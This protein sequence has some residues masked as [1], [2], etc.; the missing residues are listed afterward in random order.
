[1]IP[2]E[3]VELAVVGEPASKMLRLSGL[4]AGIVGP[5]APLYVVVR[6]TLSESEWAAIEAGRYLAAFKLYNRD[7]VVGLVL[8]LVIAGGRLRWFLNYSLRHIAEQGTPE[9]LADAVEALAAFKRDARPGMGL[10]VS[11]VF[12]DV[13][14]L[15][16]VRGLR[17][18]ALPRMFGDRFLAAIDRTSEQDLGAAIPV[19]SKLCGDCVGAWSA[20]APGVAVAGEE[21]E[22]S[23][24]DY[25]RLWRKQRER[26]RKQ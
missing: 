24:A 18:F 25:A 10:L 13:D 1:M 6:E 5:P 3:L 2:P 20:A 9:Q 7:G 14:E 19:V 21:L 8:E 4:G 22:Q 17:A 11:L 12:L 16:T 26:R 23:D 15:Q